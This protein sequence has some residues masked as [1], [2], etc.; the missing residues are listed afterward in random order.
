MKEY[1]HSN[2]IKSWAENDRPREKLISK[3][4]RHLSDAELLAILIS[5]GNRKHT[6]LDIS[7]IILK[8]FSY[9]LHELA[10]CELKD[11]MAFNGMGQAK[12][13]SVIAAF[14]LG[15]RFQN[16]SKVKL[17]S[18]RSSQ[19]AFHLMSSELID[20]KHEE[21]WIVLLN[22]ANKVQK[23]IKL[24]SGG[25][26]GTVVDIKIMMRHCL[27][28]LSSSIILYHNHPSGNLK[29]SDQDLRLTKKIVEAAALMEVKVLDHIIVA[30]DRY[31]SFLDEGLI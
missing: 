26:T 30:G 10:N 20:L 29:P 25:I 11:L 18:V 1:R 2:T 8:S 27:D 22:R 4:R 28:H 21:F 31:F 16:E 24:S 15:R 12:S 5:S 9:N 14:E 19:D 3:G 6:A 13:V 17:E 23:K 7:R